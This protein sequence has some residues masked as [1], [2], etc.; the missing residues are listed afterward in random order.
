MV[1]VSATT[2]R[3]CLIKEPPD[4]V[5]VC[6]VA[7]IRPFE[8][9][10]YAEYVALVINSPLIQ[11]QIWGNVKQS[12]QPCLYINKIQILTLPLPPLAEQKPIVA[13]VDEWMA[14]CDRLEESLR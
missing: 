14:L 3:L 2:G 9:W 13:K 6:R 1:C 4:F 8:N 12:A 5:I 7:L 10:V 11:S